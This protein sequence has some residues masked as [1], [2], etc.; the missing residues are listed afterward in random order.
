MLSGRSDSSVTLANG[1]TNTYQ[2]VR[3][4]HLRLHET[5][6]SKF[7]SDIVS[8]VSRVLVDITFNEKYG[9]VIIE[10]DATTNKCIVAVDAAACKR[11]RGIV[12]DGHTSTTISPSR[13]NVSVDVAVSESDNPFLPYFPLRLIHLLPR[14]LRRCGNANTS[15]KLVIVDVAARE[16]DVAT[17]Y[18]DTGT[19]A[20]NVLIEVA[21]SKEDRGS[22]DVNTP[23]E[24][25]SAYQF[26]L[27]R[28]SD[29]LPACR[30]RRCCS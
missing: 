11:D 10:C 13:S 14:I 18:G 3:V 17:S 15:T 12:E 24:W 5:D 29:P 16:C 28:A 6:F 1:G 23:P 26:H 22:F 8:V 21:A 19:I 2:N 7:S 25:S 30:S 9:A 4:R 20:S 27:H